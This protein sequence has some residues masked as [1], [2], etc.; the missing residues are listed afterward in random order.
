[1]ALDLPRRQRLPW[2]PPGV[3]ACAIRCPGSPVEE[4]FPRDSP[5]GPRTRLRRPQTHCLTY[6]GRRDD[7][8]HIAVLD[9]PHRRPLDRGTD[10]RGLGNCHLGL[11]TDR[12][13]LGSLGTSQSNWVCLAPQG[14]ERPWQGKCKH[15]G[16][17]RQK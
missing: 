15:W 16:Q 13:G 6:L 8:F 5:S 1:M 3:G 7:M 17:L 14:I 12:L 4:S 10:H 2:V 9:A 11:G